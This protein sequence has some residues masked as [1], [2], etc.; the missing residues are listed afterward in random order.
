MVSQSSFSTVEQPLRWHTDLAELRGNVLQQTLAATAIFA[1]GLFAAVMLYR[2]LEVFDPPAVYVLAAAPAVGLLTWIARWLRGKAGDRWAAAVLIAGLWIT[3]VSVLAVSGEDRVAFWAA[4]IV[5]LAHGTLG[6]R[7]AFALAGLTAAA[8]L[9]LGYA[10]LI[11]R[12][13]LAPIVG[14]V[15]LSAVVA[16]FGSGPTQ[17]A[18]A[19]ALN[20][21]QQAR[22]RT[23]DLRDQQVELNR[24]LRALQRANERLGQANRELERAREAADEARRLKAE[25]AAN[26]SHELRTPL[27]HIIGFATLMMTT[28]K[29]YGTPLPEGY[30]EDLEAIYRSANHLSKMIDDVLDLSQIE[31][32]RMGLVKERI[33]LSEIVQE[34]VGLVEG[35]YRAKSLALDVDVDPDLPAVYVDR[36]RIRQVIINLLSNAA[37]FTERGGVAVAAQIE[38]R[39]VVVSISDT[40]SGI[41]AEDLPKV[42]EEFQQL[43]GSI[44]R[45]HGGSGL[46]LAICKRFVELHGG[47]I[48]VDS[49]PDEGSTFSFTIPLAHTEMASAVPHP[50]AELASTPGKDDPERTIAV[51]SEDPAL[52]RILERYL[53]GFKVVGVPELEGTAL[54]CENQ[55]VD[56]LVITAGSIAEGARH[57]KTIREQCG[58]LPVIVCSLQR[59][60]TALHERGFTGRLLKPISPEALRK[61]LAGLGPDVR[62][63]MVVDDEPDSAR[64]LARMIT[65]I[66][67][68]Y[69]VTEATDGSEALATM[70]AAPPDAVLVD[71]M[72]PG[73]DGYGVLRAMREDR[74]LRGIPVVAVSAR[75]N[76]VEAIV[77]DAVV[78][79][80]AGGLAI[81]EMIEYLNASLRMLLTRP[82]SGTEPR[83]GRAS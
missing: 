58:E 15:G 79:S 26:V 31:A 30:R 32:G 70:R 24:T 81:G 68:A 46:G 11:A 21:Y 23:E 42:F 43:D 44:K 8:L 51:V 59:S 60:R 72:M 65:A 33:S 6:S 69:A 75:D 36:T 2:H 49:E 39:N 54:A 1:Y 76:P 12:D 25:F 47:T 19:W 34:A 74:R 83:P 14:F 56:A 67:D 71:L 61:R 37:R 5:L 45:R 77:A 22:A 55:S 18:L 52:S 7:A 20:S 4:I 41:A 78:T 57:I 17:T 28:P 10:D 38:G 73:L 13:T 80:P 48:H 40:G 53:D 64:L 16:W 66:S 35:A 9:G 27:N 62:R 29:I 3:V 82:D 50:A 63:I